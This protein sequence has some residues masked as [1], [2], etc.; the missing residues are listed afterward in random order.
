MNGPEISYVDLLDIKTYEASVAEEQAIAQ[1]AKPSYN[2][3][4]PSASGKCTRELAYALMEYTQQKYYPKEARDPEVTRLLSVGHYLEDQLIE[5][6][7]KYVSDYFVLRYK[8]HAVEGF[9]IECK[10]YSEVA[11]TIEGSMDWCF[12]SPDTRG[13]I[14]AKT[15]KDK[16]HKHFASDW[17]NTT[18]K[19]MNMK[20]VEVIGE[21]DKGFWIEDIQAF[22]KELKDPFFEQNFWQLNFYA[23]TPWAKGKG[24]D[25]G[26]II[27]YNKNDSRLREI[28]FKPCDELY[29]RTQIKFQ[30][31]A[32]AA[33]L[34][35]PTAAP[36]DFMFGS[37][38]CAF[39]AYKND[40]W[41]RKSKD[42]KDAFF[43]TFPK[44]KWPKDTDRITRALGDQLEDLYAIF[45]E[46]QEATDRLKEVESDILKLMEDNKIDKIRFSDN[47][48]Y[49]KKYLKSPYP[50]Y[51]LRRGKL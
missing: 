36:R 11:G 46:E 21:S 13:V 41:K 31:A 4:R 5:H 19:L 6:F 40:C 20:T 27:Q 32:S 51:E 23:S 15:K 50:H 34:G 12:W 30:D 39:C 14:D 9:E 26:S 33:E 47:R 8:Q 17:E 29:K 16:F 48:I 49:Y 24:I 35:N 44:K 42:A 18:D 43:E 2:P 10:K 3:L 45:R 37:S 22:I 1:G 38:K 28:R 7:Q 25:H